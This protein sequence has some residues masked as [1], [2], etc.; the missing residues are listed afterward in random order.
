MQPAG[1]LP[2]AKTKPT[3]QHQ[4]KT[5]ISTKRRLFYMYFSDNNQKTSNPIRSRQEDQLPQFHSK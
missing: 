2:F 1:P 5:P 4:G 3:W